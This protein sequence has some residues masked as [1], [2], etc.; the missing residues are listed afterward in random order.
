ML[1]QKESLQLLKNLTI[2][3]AEDEEM[4]REDIYEVLTLFSNNIFIAKD[5]QEAYNL[6][7]TSNPHIIIT[8]ITMPKLDG[9]SLVQKIR[10]D[11]LQVAI[12]FLTAHNDENFLLNAA[13]L[14]I[15]GYTLKATINFDTIK[16]LLLK[17]IQFL[18][19][20]TTFYINF[21]NNIK[22]DQITGKLINKDNKTIILNKKEKN[23]LNLLLKYKNQL[24]TY[25]AIESVIWDKWDETMSQTALRTLVKS[26]RSKLNL[27]IIQNIAKQGY[28]IEIL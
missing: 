11:N 27:P 23:L 9:I 20:T 5:G 10:K 14:N 16:N 4:I 7:K 6:Y 1:L 17:A 15:Q 26:L 21:N 8:D 28:K 19:L 22:Y 12:I 25:S 24:V 2:L 3:Y 13:N 18:N